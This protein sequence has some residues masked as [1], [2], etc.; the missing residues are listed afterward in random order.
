MYIQRKEKKENPI[1][2]FVTQENAITI[3][4]RILSFLT[5]C[6]KKHRLGGSFHAEIVLKFAI[7]MLN[8]NIIYGVFRKCYS[9][10]RN[11]KPFI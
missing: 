2:N 4:F 11:G 8:Y 1:S 9:N 10:V 6:L 3:L 5:L 7:R